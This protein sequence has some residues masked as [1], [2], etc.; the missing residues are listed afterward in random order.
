[1]K[2]R[3]FLFWW[4]HLTACQ[5]LPHKIFFIFFLRT[6][7]QLWQVVIYRS[8]KTYSVSFYPKEANQAHIIIAFMF[9]LY[10]HICFPCNW[11]YVFR[12]QTTSS[13][14][15]EFLSHFLYDRGVKSI[16]PFQS[17]IILLCMYVEIIS[18]IVFGV[19]FWVYIK[20]AL[21]IFM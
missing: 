9:L 3:L 19:G 4:Q 6:L 10:L 8:V 21:D 16:H 15:L 1:M 12:F 14:S 13:L 2:M 17:A 5:I 7:M 18:C 11:I 20:G